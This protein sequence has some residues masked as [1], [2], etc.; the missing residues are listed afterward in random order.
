MKRSHGNHLDGLEV[1][2]LNR[3]IVDGHGAK[4]IAAR[5]NISTRTARVRI[6]KML[7]RPGANR[8][9]YVAPSPPRKKQRK[10]DLSAQAPNAIS[11][12]SLGRLMGRR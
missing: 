4:E 7:G 3:M 11:G 12:I 8:A 10:L 2:E 6:S 1:E 9:R 5:F